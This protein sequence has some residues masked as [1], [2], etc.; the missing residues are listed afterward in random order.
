MTTALAGV[1]F[2]LGART[3]S[4]AIAPAAGGCA[5][6]TLVG[7]EDEHTG[8]FVQR[9]QSTSQRSFLGLADTSRPASAL[10]GPA[11]LAK[12]NGME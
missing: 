11:L 9:L 12:Q 4:S 5:A 3:T 10:R 2:F 8:C 6:V 1:P 7:L